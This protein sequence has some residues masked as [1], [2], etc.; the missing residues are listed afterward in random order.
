MHSFPECKKDNRRYFLI[1]IQGNEETIVDVILNT[2]NMSDIGNILCFNETEV[3]YL[4]VLDA[5][6]A[7][8]ACVGVDLDNPPEVQDEYEINGVVY[9][10]NKDAP[11]SEKKVKN[12]IPTV[13]DDDDDV[14]NAP[15]T[16]SEDFGEKLEIPVVSD[17]VRYKEKS[18]IKPVSDEETVEVNSDNKKTRA[19]NGPR[20]PKGR[21]GEGKKPVKGIDLELEQELGNQ[22]TYD[23]E[24]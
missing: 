5:D 16:T 22:K 12:E 10:R 2:K 6:I 18:P 3:R 1:K 11:K 4:I 7:G 19:T 9:T 24:L 14:L 21:A 17:E 20:D 13:I 8:Q 23:S 15:T